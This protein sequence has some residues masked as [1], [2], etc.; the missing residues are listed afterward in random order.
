MKV[1]SEMNAELNS[2]FRVGFTVCGWLQYY[3]FSF[4]DID[5]CYR[6]FGPGNH[7]LNVS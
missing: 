1:G 3:S 6:H 4:L 5:N 2:E 7:S